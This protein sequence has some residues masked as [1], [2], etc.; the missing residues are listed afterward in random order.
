MTTLPVCTG[1]IDEYNY[2]NVCY[3]GESVKTDPNLLTTDPVWICGNGDN[4]TCLHGDDC[5][6]KVKIP[7]TRPA[8]VSN[9]VIEKW[10]DKGCTGKKIITTRYNAD[11]AINDNEI[12][13]YNI[14][15]KIVPFAICAATSINGVIYEQDIF[16]SV[17]AEAI[18]QNELVNCR[19]ITDITL[20][21]QETDLTNTNN[22]KLSEYAINPGCHSDYWMVRSENENKDNITI[23]TLGMVGGGIVV[24]L[25]IYYYV[26]KR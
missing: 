18:T 26:Y 14:N 5:V 20:P 4:C 25:C 24:I 8:T 16:R 13:N 9:V 3:E 12:G 23:M 2:N 21:G 6:E 22:I 1:Y 11:G 10:S 15:G 19:S 17:G 7:G